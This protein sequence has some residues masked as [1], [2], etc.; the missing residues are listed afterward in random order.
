MSSHV[1]SLSKADRVETAALYTSI[2]QY[3]LSQPNF[4]ELTVEDPAEAFEDLRDRVDLKMLL[5]NSQFKAEAFE[6]E[7]H[8]GGRVG[9]VGR[10]GKSGRGGKGAAKTGG[11]IGPP[12]QKAWAEKWRL[13]LKIAKVR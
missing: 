8:G 4:G 6:E 9:G 5:S 1:P 12:T 7:S 13:Q 2:H 10:K 11:K 3:V